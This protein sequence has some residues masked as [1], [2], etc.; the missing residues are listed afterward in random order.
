ML[1]DLFIGL[2]ATIFAISFFIWTPPYWSACVVLGVRAIGSVFHMP[3]IQAV[4]PMLVPQEELVRANGWSQFLQ[5]GAF[6]VGPIL[7][8][9]MYA[10]LPLP[11]ILLSDLVGSVVAS[12]SVAVVKIPEIKHGKQTRRDFIGEIKEGIAVY[13]SDKKLSI[14]TLFMAVSMVFFM[15]LASFY[16]LMTSDYFKATAW[17]ASLAWSIWGLLY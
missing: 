5:S 11:I 4:V 13:L 12:I 10:A 3:A 16:P 14:V 7:G 6:I 15:P 8:A 9:A 17:H 2:I 1:T